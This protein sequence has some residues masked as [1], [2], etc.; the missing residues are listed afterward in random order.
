[1]R[2]IKIIL[3]HHLCIK[4]CWSTFYHIYV[5]YYITLFVVCNNCVNY[6]YWNRDNYL[7]YKFI[8]YFLSRTDTYIK[9]FCTRIY[10]AK[11]QYNRIKNFFFFSF[12]NMFGPKT[13]HVWIYTS[14]NDLRTRV[15]LYYG[16]FRCPS[17]TLHYIPIYRCKLLY[18]F[19]WTSSIKLK[20]IVNFFVILIITK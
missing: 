17:W 7:C 19:F 11:F 9:H 13:Y 3:Y 5:Y 16:T 18:Y 4:S 6:L 1:M 14:A 10:F 12:S 2:L 15:Q 20:L 8:K